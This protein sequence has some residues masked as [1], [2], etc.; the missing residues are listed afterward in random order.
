MT[1]TPAGAGDHAGTPAGEP[2][3]ATT[4]GRAERLR[5]IAHDLRNCLY[6]MGMAA[7]IL[8]TVPVEGAEA[9]AL[10]ES[11]AKDRR[12]AEGLVADFLDAAGDGP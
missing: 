1:P 4:E 6:T 7:E 3:E 8:R 5:R 2:A 12:T 11:I 10:W 9:A